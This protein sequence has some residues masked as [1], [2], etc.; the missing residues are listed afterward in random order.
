MKNFI[1]TILFVCGV[2]NMN[3]QTVQATIKKAS[4]GCVTV[5]A[6]PTANVMDPPSNFLFSVS[7]PDQVGM[8]GTNPNAAT[9]AVLTDM[10]LDA[11]TPAP[12]ILGGRY[13]IDLNFTPSVAN[14]APLEW[15]AGQEYPLATICFSGATPPPVQAMVQIN[16]LTA[17]GGGGNGFSYW[18]F[19]VQ[20]AGDLTDYG[21]NFYDDGG[22]TAVANNGGDSQAE[23]SESVSL[24]IELR[25]FTVSKN[26]KSVDLYWSTSSEINASHFEVER[27]IDGQNWNYLGEVK[28][29]GESSIIQNYTF[30]DNNLPL[31][32]RQDHKL[33]YYRLNMVDN[34]DN[35]EYS[36]VRIARFD[37]DGE[38]DFLVYPN[39]SIDEVYVNLSSITDESGPANMNVINMNGQLIKQVSLET[40]DDI[41]VDVG[42]MTA[43]VYYFVVRQGEQT[44][45][46]KIIKID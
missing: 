44:Y 15:I 33:F 39:P 11:G 35:Q 29:V 5:F 41:R 19:E 2:L 37:L 12:Y 40:S 8:G 26:E 43:G 31:Y 14:P 21:A 24:P 16:D 10:Q 34:D 45:S 13:Y 7:V 6:R 20:G 23:T 17:T 42:D 4:E 27:S 25:N 1:Y 22:V 38:A 32:S 28:A 3:A 46:Q 36:E 30:L 9:S 18:Y